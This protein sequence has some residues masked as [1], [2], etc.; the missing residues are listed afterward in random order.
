MKSNDLSIHAFRLKP[1]QDLKQE[2]E[3]FVISQDIEAGWIITCAGSL[4]QTNI[5]Y[6]SQPGGVIMKGHFEIV[7]LSGTVSIH[8]SHLHISISDGSGKTTGGHLLDGN[9][10]YTTAELVIGES[11]QLVFTREKDGSSPWKELQVNEKRS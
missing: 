11:K 2:I 5:R 7:S 4:V 1:G 10:I 8:G 9:L 6:A 3:R